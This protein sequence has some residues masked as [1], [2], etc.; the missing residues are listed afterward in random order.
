MLTDQWA[1]GE[2]RLYVFLPRGMY[3][4]GEV[5]HLHG[6]VLE[7]YAI[8]FSSGER[9][10]KHRRILFD[11]LV[12]VEVRSKTGV[13]HKK[14]DSFVIFSIEPA[15]RFSVK[16]TFEVPNL[17]DNDSESEHSDEKASAGE[18]RLHHFSPSWRHHPVPR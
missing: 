9:E 11:L 7:M 2:H 1:R 15:M 17:A 14:L 12:F 5:F 4:C 16:G 10:A 3:F 8:Q 18:K 6:N 13:F